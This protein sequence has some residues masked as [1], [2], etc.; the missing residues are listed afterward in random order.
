MGGATHPHVVLPKTLLSKSHA[1]PPRPGSR[2]LLTSAALEVSALYTHMATGPQG[3]TTAEA[4]SRLATSFSQWRRF[5]A[6]RQAQ[7][8]GQ[9]ERIVGAEGLSKDTFEIATRSLK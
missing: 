2:E 3:L 7:I 9:L 1:Q 6:G 5:D 8:R 4:A